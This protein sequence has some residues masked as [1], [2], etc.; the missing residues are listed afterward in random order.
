MWKK[1]GRNIKQIMAR[2]SRK[3]GK[4]MGRN[5]KQIMARR[6]ANVEKYGQEYYSNCGQRGS[7]YGTYSKLDAYC[8]QD[9]HAENSVRP[10][11]RK[12]EKIWPGKKG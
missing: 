1:V 4:K 2:K 10:G 11:K 6:A 8:V 9:F 3:Y 7:K 12:V 5:I